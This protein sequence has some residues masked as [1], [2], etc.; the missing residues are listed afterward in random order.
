MQSFS[1]YGLCK[2]TSSGVHDKQGKNR[3]FFIVCLLLGACYQ[4]WDDVLDGDV[5]GK[6]PLLAHPPYV[7]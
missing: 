2:F 6:Y 7:K 1:V 4:N 3:F 5:C